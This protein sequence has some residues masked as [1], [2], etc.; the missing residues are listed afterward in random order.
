ME[1]SKLNFKISFLEAV[2]GDGSGSPGGDLNIADKT[3]RSSYEFFGTRKEAEADIA[4]FQSRESGYVR[5]NFSI[6]E[7]DPKKFLLYIK[8]GCKLIVGD[9]LQ[10]P[11]DEWTIYEGEKAPELGEPGLGKHNCSN[12]IAYQ[13]CDEIDC[14]PHRGIVEKVESYTKERAIELGLE[15][16]VLPGENLQVTSEDGKPIVHPQCDL[17]PR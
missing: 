7:I 13:S 5:Y 17:S 16:K 6:S 10:G 8:Y 9:G 3:A 2:P 4:Q 15:K 12:H 1:E 11:R 14:F